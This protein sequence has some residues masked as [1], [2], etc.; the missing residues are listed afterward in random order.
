MTLVALDRADPAWAELVAGAPEATAFHHPAWTSVLADTYG[1]PSVV[2]AEPGLA[3][4]VVLA[5]VPRLRGRAWISLPFSDHCPPLARDAA[6]L[7]RLS[8][9]LA[10]WAAGERAS[11]E[12]RGCLP[13]AR[14]WSDAAIGV[15]HVLPLGGDPEVLLASLDRSLRRRLRQGERAGLEVRF[16]TS[17]DDVADF[18]RLQ[19]A[20]RRRHG[21][22]VQPRRFFD[23]IRRHLLD[24]GLGVIALAAPRGGRPV[25]AAMALAWNGIAIFKY[26]A[27]DTSAWDLHPNH[28]LY[29][30]MIRWAR[31][32]GCGRLDLGR[33]ETRHEG[34]RQWKTAWGAEEIPLSY[35]HTG[36]AAP[37]LDRGAL[38]AA[39]GHVIRRSPTIICRGVGALLYRYSA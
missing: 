22:P 34:L 2:L 14:A 16:G 4:G 5:R 10:G 20:T 29:W 25:A 6:A 8:D 35:S 11:V 19:V 38:G 23:A 30:A 39:L 26:Q 13:A 32:A 12:V 3:A 17:A 31:E 33:T 18:H 27:S 9:G 24:Q 7:Q 15:R 36:G 21:V 37:T 28:A 1:Y